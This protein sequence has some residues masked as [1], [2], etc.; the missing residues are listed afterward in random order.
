VHIGYGSG[1]WLT[2]W[3]GDHLLKKLH[4]EISFFISQGCT[5]EMTVTDK[6]LD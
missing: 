6:N 1:R 4:N 3:D 5:L 2:P